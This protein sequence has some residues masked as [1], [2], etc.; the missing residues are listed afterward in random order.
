MY[1]NSYQSQNSLRLVIDW[2]TQQE[3]QADYVMMKR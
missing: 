3:H 2:S 1:C